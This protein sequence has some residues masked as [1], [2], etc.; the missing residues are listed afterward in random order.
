LIGGRLD[1]AEPATARS[2]AISRLSQFQTTS[3]SL[4]DGIVKAS[5]NPV[6]ATQ[7]G[8]TLLQGLDQ[9]RHHPTS[10]FIP[11]RRNAASG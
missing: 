1:G 5:I 6:A 2:E 9:P 8:V 4:M 10:P 3:T 11:P 7:G